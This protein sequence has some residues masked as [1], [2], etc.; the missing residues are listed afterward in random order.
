MCDKLFNQG[1]ANWSYWPALQTCGREATIAMHKD[2]HWIVHVQCDGTIQAL[3]EQCGD[4]IQTNP[5]RHGWLLPE[6]VSPDDCHDNSYDASDVRV[7]CSIS[8]CKL[9]R[10]G[11]IKFAIAQYEDWAHFWCEH[12][13]SEAKRSRRSSFSSFLSFSFPPPPFPLSLLL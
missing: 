1:I 11:T 12:N 2:L 13:R 3:H 6:F 7:I 8:P 10:M 4:V 5:C 9:F